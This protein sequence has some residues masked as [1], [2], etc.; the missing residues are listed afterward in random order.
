MNDGFL[1]AN[2]WK[3]TTVTS[4]IALFAVCLCIRT[5]LHLRLA[6]MTSTIIENLY[7]ISELWT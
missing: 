3:R 4:G 2:E 6:T 7:R 1:T 5:Y